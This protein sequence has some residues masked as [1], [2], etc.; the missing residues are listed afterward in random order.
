MTRLHVIND[1]HSG[2]VWQVRHDAWHWVTRAYREIRANLLRLSLDRR[3]ASKEAR[4]AV[5][6]LL[7]AGYTA[8]RTRGTYR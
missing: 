6:A 1:R 4:W 3:W 5:L 2:T 7:H 8:S